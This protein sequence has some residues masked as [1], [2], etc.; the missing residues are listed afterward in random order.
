MQAYKLCV[1]L[2][3]DVAVMQTSKFPKEFEVRFI[4]A[5]CWFYIWEMT[6]NSH[7]A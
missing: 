7:A 1:I 6:D 5:V 2:Y 4:T 3:N